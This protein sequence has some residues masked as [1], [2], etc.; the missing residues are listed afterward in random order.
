MVR[1]NFRSAK[2]ASDPKKQNAAAERHKLQQIIKIRERLS[3][4]KSSLN[5]HMLMS[6]TMLVVCARIATTPKAVSSLLSCASTRIVNFMQEVFARLATF[7]STIIDYEMLKKK[8]R[9]AQMASNKTHLIRPK[10]K[11][12]TLRE[13]KV[14]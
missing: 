14:E 3:T 2:T 5:V 7:A 13:M 1:S 11:K 8:R 10:T 9:Q 12:P 6:I 4:E